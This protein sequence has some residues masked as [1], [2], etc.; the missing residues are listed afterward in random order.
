M[1]RKREE[2]GLWRLLK[3]AMGDDSVFDLFVSIPPHRAVTSMKWTMVNFQPARLKKMR[4]I[5][6]LIITE[7]G[8]EAYIQTRW[9]HARCVCPWS[10]MLTPCKC[11]A[12][13]EEVALRARFEHQA[14]D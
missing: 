3:G 6:A 12:I 10:M 11:G 1:A 4:G 8:D 13:E 7:R 5:A 9:L 14:E 2:D